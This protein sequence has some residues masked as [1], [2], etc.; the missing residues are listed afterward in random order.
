MMKAA[1]DEI[2]REK[3]SRTGSSKQVIIIIIIMRIRR[4]QTLLI[5]QLYI[6]QCY[7]H[8]PFILV[9]LSIQ[10]S[11]SPP[12]PSPTPSQIHIRG[13]ETSIP[14]ILVPKDKSDR[15]KDPLHPNA[16]GGGPFSCCQK[17]ERE[18]ER[19]FLV[20]GLYLFFYTALSIFTTHVQRCV[21]ERWSPISWAGRHYPIN[22]IYG[23]KKGT[24]L[25]DVG[26]W[27]VQVL[28]MPKVV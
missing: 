22:W 17:G 26:Y 27:N 1:A 14:G 6:S 13:L 23:I 9:S 8:P 19:V 18:R 25:L 21:W 15:L 20:A 7:T 5:T 2:K 11:I 28:D 12:T 24:G 16:D 3:E 10:Q 4:K